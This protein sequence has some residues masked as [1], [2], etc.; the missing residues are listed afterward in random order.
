MIYGIASI[1]IREENPRDRQWFDLYG[2]EEEQ[3]AYVKSECDLGEIDYE[4]YVQSMRENGGDSLPWARQNGHY[5]VPFAC[6]ITT[7][8]APPLT[9]KKGAPLKLDSKE[10]QMVLALRAEAAKITKIETRSAV[11]CMAT[12]IENYARYGWIDAVGT[13]LDTAQFLA[14]KHVSSPFRKAFQKGATLLQRC[15]RQYDK[16]LRYDK[17]ALYGKGG[18]IHG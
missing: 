4:E 14:K 8:E 10:K 6:V 5:L 1:D 18:K 17:D 7:E 16:G 13:V 3:T 2:S 9:L 11:R 12:M 15:I